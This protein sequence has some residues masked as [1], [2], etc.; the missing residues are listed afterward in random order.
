CLLRRCPTRS[1]TIVGDAGQTRAPGA[2]GSWRASLDRVLGAESWRIEELTINYRTPAAVVA[3]A[4][5]L[6]RSAGLPVGR[7]TAARDVPNSLM[8]CPA[9]DPVAEAVALA[10][11]RLP[12]GETGRVA[13]IAAGSALAAVRAAIAGGDLASKVA[14]PRQ[15]PLD[16]PLAVLDAAEVKGLEFDEVIIVDPA[17]VA[18]GVVAA[19]GGAAA[20][21]AAAGGAVAGGA[22]AGGAAAESAWP[23]SELD[24]R[25]GAADLYVAMTRPTR[26]L[27]LVR[28]RNDGSTP[29][30]PTGRS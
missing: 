3:A 23:I 13:L 22:V 28:P 29:P 11:R 6:A 18:G 1:L 15:D 30:E 24:R 14:R 19:A 2:T 10:R 20:G 5:E 25:A 21:G 27:W 7:D 16:F 26:R 9:D 12:R 17:A 4:Q 8:D